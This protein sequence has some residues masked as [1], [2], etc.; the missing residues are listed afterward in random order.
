LPVYFVCHSAAQPIPRHPDRKEYESVIPTGGGVLCRRSGGTPAFRRCRCL[1]FVVASPCSSDS[2]QPTEVVIPPT[3]R[4]S[5]AARISVLALAL[6]LAGRRPLHPH[7]TQLIAHSSNRNNRRVPHLRRSLIAAKVG[8]YR[9]PH[10]SQSYR[11]GWDSTPRKNPSKSPCQDPRS[12]KFH[13]TNT[14]QTTYPI[15]IV[16]ILVSLHGV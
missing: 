9:V 2:A 10:P 15:K 3:S 8:P 7:T 12:P 14:N 1:F 11:D 4:H 6:A 5:G 13:L 16:G